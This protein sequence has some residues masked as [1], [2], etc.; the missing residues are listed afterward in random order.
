MYWDK[1]DD[2]KNSVD[3]FVQDNVPVVAPKIKCGL[4]VC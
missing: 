2:A 1:T 4:N 3:T